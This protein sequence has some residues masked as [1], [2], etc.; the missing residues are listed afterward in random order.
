VFTGN[1]KGKTTVEGVTYQEIIFVI[2]VVFDTK[3]EEWQ[4]PT[5]Q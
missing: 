2:V 3:S 5:L 4:K 1:G